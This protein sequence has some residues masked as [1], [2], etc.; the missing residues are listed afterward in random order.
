MYAVAAD[1]GKEL[2]KPETQELVNGEGQGA[3][4]TMVPPADLGTMSCKTEV[5]NNKVMD[6]YA[7]S[8]SFTIQSGGEQFEIKVPNEKVGLII[9]KGGETIKNLQTRSGARI[10]VKILM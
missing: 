8:C 4:S 2:H 9:G 10:Q 3:Q 5:P 6:A 7:L 1:T